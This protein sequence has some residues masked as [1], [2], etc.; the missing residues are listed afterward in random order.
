MENGAAQIDLF[1]RFGAA[2]LIGLLV[3][4]QREFTHVRRKEEENLGDTGLYL[5]SIAS[6]RADSAI[7]TLT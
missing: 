4:L 7:E 2:L 6:R 1:Y 3:G 5:S